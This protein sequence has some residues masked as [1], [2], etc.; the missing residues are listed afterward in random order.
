[1]LFSQHF[2]VFHLDVFQEI[3][4]LCYP[5][6]FHSPYNNRNAST[7]VDEAKLKSF[8]LDPTAS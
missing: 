8:P 4:I 5:I 7:E 2:L 3:S 1:M 6:S